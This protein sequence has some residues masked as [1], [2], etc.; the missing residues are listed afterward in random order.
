MILLKEYLGLP[1]K[2]AQHRLNIQGVSYER[3]GYRDPRG[4]APG[5]DS[6]VVRALLDHGT[7]RLTYC[8][9]KTEP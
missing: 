5:E 9:F 6:R 7:V 4:N 3:S 8:D 1:L 2:L